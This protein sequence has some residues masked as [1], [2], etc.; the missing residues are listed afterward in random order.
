MFIFLFAHSPKRHLGFMK[1]TE[2]MVTKGNKFFRNVKIKWISMFEPYQKS[3]D[4]IQN[5]VYENGLG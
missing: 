1:I 5:L 2:L 3:Y 4:I